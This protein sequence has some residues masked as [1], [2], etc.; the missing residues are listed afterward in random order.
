MEKLESAL[1]LRLSKVYGSA[2]RGDLLQE[3]A[4]KLARGEIVRAAR[5]QCFNPISIADAVRAVI[6]LCDAGAN[7]VV[8]VCGPQAWCRVEL[9]RAVASALDAT[10]GLVEEISLDDLDE[11]FQRPKDTRMSADRLAE[12]TAV[13]PAG[14]DGAI[15]ALEGR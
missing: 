5:D 2:P 7:G 6:E 1:V 4:D 15:A 10:S 11:P 9:A 3:M 13:R 14:V 12:L 8:N